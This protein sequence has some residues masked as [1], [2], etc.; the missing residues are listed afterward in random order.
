MLLRH[1]MTKWLTLAK[2]SRAVAA[3]NGYYQGGR[4]TAEIFLAKAVSRF[5]GAMRPNDAKTFA[6]KVSNRV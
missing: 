1:V 5:R 6:P 4:Q 3:R 2:Q